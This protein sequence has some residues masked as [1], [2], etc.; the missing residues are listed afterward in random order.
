MFALKTS[1]RP[2][3]TS[4]GP[5]AG[6]HPLAWIYYEEPF[7]YQLFRE[8]SFTDG[9]RHKRHQGGRE[10]GQLGHFDTLTL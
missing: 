10:E 2:Q 8:K 7:S 9:V 6:I 3:A 1:R 5:G 4:Y